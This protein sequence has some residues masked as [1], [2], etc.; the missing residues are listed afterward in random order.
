MDIIKIFTELAD[1]GGCPA[2]INDDNGHWA[3]TDEGLQ[4]VPDSDEPEDI[5]TT[6]FV[7]KGKWKDTIEEAV[8]YY[9]EE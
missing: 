4:S 2:L 1:E 9:L 7:E 3:V 5:H 6:F 8:K